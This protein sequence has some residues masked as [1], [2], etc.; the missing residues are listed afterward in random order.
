MAVRDKAARAVDG[1]DDALDGVILCGLFELLQPAFGKRRADGAR[2][3]NHG[4]AIACAFVAR[5]MLFGDA[6]R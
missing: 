6:R 1:H 2:E 5:Q 4:D 3:V